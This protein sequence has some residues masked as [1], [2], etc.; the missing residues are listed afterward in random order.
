VIDALHNNVSAAG[1]EANF[2]VSAPMRGNPLPKK[3]AKI[4]PIAV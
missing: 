1:N 4:S 3:E 2:F